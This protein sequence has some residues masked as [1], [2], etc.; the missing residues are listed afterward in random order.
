MKD[1]SEELL[2]DFSYE[3]IWEVADDLRDLYKNK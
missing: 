1:L 3:E 2:E